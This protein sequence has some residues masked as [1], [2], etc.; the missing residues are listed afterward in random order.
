MGA[1]SPLPSPSPS[2]SLGRCCFSLLLLS[3]RVACLLLLWEVLFHRLPLSWR[4]VLLYSQLNLGG[5]VR[6]SS[7]L[8]GATRFL[9]WVVLFRGLGSGSSWRLTTVVSQRRREV[10]ILRLWGR[11]FF[12]CCFFYY[13]YCVSCCLGR[14]A[15]ALSLSLTFA[16]VTLFLPCS[17]SGEGREWRGRGEYCSSTLVGDDSSSFRWCCSLP[18]YLLHFFLSCFLFM[19]YF[20]F[21][22][23][24]VVFS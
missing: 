1:A 10:Q 8:A 3:C 16:M 4:V 17:F 24:I 21:F 11:W 7:T 9:L 6:C 12:G 2:P 22:F 13:W 15:L 23:V 20:V 18:L 19:V 14:W 5:A